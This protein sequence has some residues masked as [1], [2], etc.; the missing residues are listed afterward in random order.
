MIWGKREANNED[1]QD[2]ISKVPEEFLVE[3]NEGRQ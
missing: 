2:F 1:E 3:L